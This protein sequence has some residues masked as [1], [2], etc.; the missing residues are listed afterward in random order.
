MS[1]Y[2]CHENCDCIEAVV[3]V[4]VIRHFPGNSEQ[5]ESQSRK[6]GCR[7]GV[8]RKSGKEIVDTLKQKHMSSFDV[9]II[10]A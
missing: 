3:A 2:I 10:L 6:K 1:K 9:K 4:C 5:D 8:V 7:D